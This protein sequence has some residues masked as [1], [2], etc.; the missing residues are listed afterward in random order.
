MPNFLITE[1][2]VNFEAVGNVINRTPLQVENSY[3]TLPTTP[4]LGV[5]L[6]FDWIDNQTKKLAEFTR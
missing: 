1:Y 2:F 5:D 6:D 3:I 4:G